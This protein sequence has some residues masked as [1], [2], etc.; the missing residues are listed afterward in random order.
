MPH[1]DP[2]HEGTNHTQQVLLKDL[3]KSQGPRKPRKDSD[4]DKRYNVL[5]RIVRKLQGR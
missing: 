1:I 4:P 5:Q 2:G 3:R